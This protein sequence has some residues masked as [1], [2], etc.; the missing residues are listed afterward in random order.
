M[1][2]LAQTRALIDT[3]H[4][5]A[6]PRVSSYVPAHPW[7]LET[8]YTNQLLR[9]IA[10]PLMR[11]TWDCLRP[12]VMAYR[13]PSERRDDEYSE[14]TMALG[15]AQLRFAQEVDIN[16][17]AREAVAATAPKVEAFALAQQAKSL[18]VLGI[19]AV[20]K[21]LFLDGERRA[22]TRANVELIQT[23]P[24]EYFPKVEK[25]IIQAVHSGMRH[26]TL[27]K[28]LREEVLPMSKTRS[29]V[30]A[31]DQVSKYNGSLAKAQQTAVG[32]ERYQWRAVHDRRTRET[33]LA[34]DMTIQRW[35]QAPA[36]G[37]PGEPIM[38]RCV[39]CCVI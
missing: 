20:G 8:Y 22:W 3:I 7:H 18:R 27:A 24:G 16:E 10:N 33:H 35:D 6:K 5:R 31:R 38:C 19:D 4:P 15:E 29:G 14:F 30:I 1:Q 34:L 12:V 11:I 26:E 17:E 36:I 37:H 28:K 32:I 25:H 39:S 23:I 13:A 9:R 2:H 21:D